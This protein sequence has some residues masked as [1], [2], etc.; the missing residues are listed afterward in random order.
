[1]SLE[2]L[3]R[4]RGTAGPATSGGTDAGTDNNR[5]SGCA[6]VVAW[7]MPEI[8]LNVPEIRNGF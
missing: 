3:L 6:L 1:M 2:V 8:V 4:D 7:V 5:S